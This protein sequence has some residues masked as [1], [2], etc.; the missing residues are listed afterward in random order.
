[1]AFGAIFPT[2]EGA[3]QIVFFGLDPT[4]SGAFTPGLRKHSEK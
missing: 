2:E 3:D 1:M 4:K